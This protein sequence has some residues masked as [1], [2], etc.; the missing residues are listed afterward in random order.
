MRFGMEYYAGRFQQL[1]AERY[2]RL[3]RGCFAMGHMQ[4]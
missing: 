2:S 1:A 4:I 3:T